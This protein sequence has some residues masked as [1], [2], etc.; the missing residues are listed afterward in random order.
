MRK[1]SQE[2]TKNGTGKLWLAH[3]AQVG[4]QNPDDVEVDSTIICKFQI[5]IRN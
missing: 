3:L 5:T 4:T 1:L 2:Y